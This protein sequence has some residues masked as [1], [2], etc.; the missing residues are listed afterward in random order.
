M[1]FCEECGAQLEDDAIFCEECGTPVEEIESIQTSEVVPE[2]ATEVEEVVPEAVTEVDGSENLSQIEKESKK[3]NDKKFL[4][5]IITVVAVLFLVGIVVVFASVAGK[6]S[7]IDSKETTSKTVAIGSTATDNVPSEETNV[8][9][10][11]ETEEETTTKEDAITEET[12]TEKTTIEEEATT[13][14]ETTIEE[15][16]IMEEETTAAEIVTEEE[17][18]TEE[19]EEELINVFSDNLSEGIM[20]W[21]YEVF[22]SEI[23]TMNVVENS[24]GKYISIDKNENGMY[25]TLFYTDFDEELVLGV[26]YVFTKQSLD[27]DG[28]KC[29][30]E[31]K[32]TAYENGIDISFNYYYDD[33]IV[34]VCNRFY[35]KDN[36]DPFTFIS[37]DSNVLKYQ[38]MGILADNNSNCFY[39]KIKDGEVYAIFYESN[40]DESLGLYCSFRS[41]VINDYTQIIELNDYKGNAL[42]FITNELF[43]Y[44]QETVL[45]AKPNS[46]GWIEVSNYTDANGHKQY[47]MT[48]C[49]C[50]YEIR[51]TFTEE[52]IDIYWVLNNNSLE[53]V[54]YDGI[55]ADEN[56]NKNIWIINQ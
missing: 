19:K 17:S 13:E 16:T 15:E 7:K 31:L 54:I 47:D 43:Y 14:E 6:N 27:E 36:F 21:R 49:N 41:D 11:T 46:G 25:K 37:K 44:N 24:Q 30:K 3:R 23:I 1:K 4:I 38:P 40:R 42:L 18:T 48:G 39:K 28:N 52:Y 51:V 5:I 26:E 56:M 10:E 9:K 55:I 29:K 22:I 8:D 12:T 34:E 53:T 45:R 35:D 50:Y 2:I 20:S 33:S 32:I